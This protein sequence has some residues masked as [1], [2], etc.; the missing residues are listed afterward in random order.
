MDAASSPAA[1]GNGKHFRVDLLHRSPVGIFAGLT[2]ATLA[3]T[4][5]RGGGTPTTGPPIGLAPAAFRLVSYDSCA[6][7]LGQL[8]RAA[9]DY[10]TPYGIGGGPF[11]PPPGGERAV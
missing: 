6:D 3:M 4:A 11:P 9:A 2:A 7:A 5:C 8:K 10:V 1:P